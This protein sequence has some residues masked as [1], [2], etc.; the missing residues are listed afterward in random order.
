MGCGHS[1]GRSRIHKTTAVEIF[2]E[3]QAKSV[4]GAS[5]VKFSHKGKEIKVYFKPLSR[6]HEM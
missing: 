2:D 6:N 3:E 1:T 5:L 4:Q